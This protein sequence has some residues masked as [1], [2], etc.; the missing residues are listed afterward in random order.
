MI[1]DYDGT[2][3]LDAAGEKVG[4]VEHSYDDEEGRVHLVEVQTG[5][6]LHKHRLVPVDDSQQVAAGLQVPYTKE[7]IMDSPDAKDVDGTLDGD[8]LQQVRAYY[9]GTQVSFDG[10]NHAAGDDEEDGETTAD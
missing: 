2:D 6:L 8:A 10:A 4:T 1:N 9:A 3:V 7:T 5:H